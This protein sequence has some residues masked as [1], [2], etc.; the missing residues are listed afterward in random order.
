[1]PIIPFSNQYPNDAYNHTIEELQ[2]KTTNKKVVVF[3][4][5]GTLTKPRFGNNTWESIWLAL[6]YPLSICEEL[7][8]KFS[9]K[10]INH[11]EWCEITEKYFKERKLN[12]TIIKQ[13]SKN[14][15]LMDDIPTVLDEL[16]KHDICFYILSGSIKQYIQFALGSTLESYF[17]EIKANR[18]VFDDDGYLE[19]IIG[20]PYDFEGKARFVKKIITTKGILPNEV[21]FIG[22]SFND[23]FVYTSGVETL[24]LNPINTSFYNNRIWHHYERNVTSLKC[25]LKYIITAHS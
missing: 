21:L 2:N 15:E 6:G 12:E 3:D 10:E 9:R 23:E 17:T 4:F 20:T 19:G 7:H 11:D 8:G 1:M 5:D 13:L 24:C 25:I 22:N 14:V 16:K 18:F